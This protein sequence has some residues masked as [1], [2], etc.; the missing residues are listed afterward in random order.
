MPP[1]IAAA[2]LFERRLHFGELRALLP[3][4][5]REEHAGGLTDHLLFGP[6]EDVVSALVPCGHEAVEVHCDNGIIGSAVEKRLQKAIPV[7]L[8]RP[9]VRTVRHCV[10]QPATTA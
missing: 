8:R 5:Q 1:L 7:E 10:D 2:A 4:L 3:I 6:A 9:T